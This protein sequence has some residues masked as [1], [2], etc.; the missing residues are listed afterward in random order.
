MITP[1]QL[2]AL[3]LTI[4]DQRIQ[5]ANLQQQNQALTLKLQQLEKTDVPLDAKR[6]QAQGD[7]PDEPLPQPARNG[8]GHHHKGPKGSKRPKQRT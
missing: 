8:N 3:S 6:Q 7:F 5:I 1:D 2:T 4:A